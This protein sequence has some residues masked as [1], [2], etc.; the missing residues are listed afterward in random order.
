[1]IQ[2]LSKGNNFA[3]PT[4]EYEVGSTSRQVQVKHLVLEVVMK[5]VSL[6][7]AATYFSMEVAIM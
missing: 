6:V 3:Q 7:A 2:S 5:Y 1:M 4:R